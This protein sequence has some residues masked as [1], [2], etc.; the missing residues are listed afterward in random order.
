VQAGTKADIEGSDGSSAAFAGSVELKQKV[1][2]SFASHLGIR[3]NRLD[4]IAPGRGDPKR[5]TPCLLTPEK[6]AIWRNGS[7]L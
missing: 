6:E 1:A 5:R 2:V 7:A 4:Q 3:W